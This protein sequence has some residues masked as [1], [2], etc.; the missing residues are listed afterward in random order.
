MQP[1]ERV[2]EAERASER[3]LHDQLAITRER[4][5]LAGAPLLGLLGRCRP[6]DAA[7]RDDMREQGV[8]FSVG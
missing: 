7:A 8:T 4:A 3:A 1:V 6:L 5:E 2:L